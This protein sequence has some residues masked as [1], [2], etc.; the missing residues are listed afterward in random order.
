MRGD[1]LGHVPRECAAAL[2]SV[3]DQHGEL[4][5]EGNIPRGSGHRSFRWF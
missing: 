1:Q 2:A 5:V 3:M 4:R